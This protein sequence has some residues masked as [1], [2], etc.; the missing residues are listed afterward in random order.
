MTTS[1]CF[2]N[3]ELNGFSNMHFWNLILRY[4]SLILADK[5][6]FRLIIIIIIVGLLYIAVV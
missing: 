6:L 3:V 5:A 2:E 1:L 4:F